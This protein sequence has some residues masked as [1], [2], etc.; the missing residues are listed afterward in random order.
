MLKIFLPQGDFFW[1]KMTKPEQNNEFKVN[2]ETI[3]IMPGVSPKNTDYSE[4]TDQLLGPPSAL[5]EVPAKGSLR[6]AK[7]LPKK[8]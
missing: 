2:P 1:A 8:P 5:N 7:K 4:F 6:L 3:G